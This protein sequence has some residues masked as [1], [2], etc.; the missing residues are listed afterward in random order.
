ML[1]V[2]Q[3]A[4]TAALFRSHVLPV[5]VP[6][7]F[8]VGAVLEVAFGS[9]GVPFALATISQTIATVAIGCAAH[10]KPVA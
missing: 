2:A 4:V 9:G 6:I 1:L 10:R 7:L 8:V 5:W 3:I